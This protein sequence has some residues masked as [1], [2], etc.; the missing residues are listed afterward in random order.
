MTARVDAAAQFGDDGSLTLWASRPALVDLGHALDSKV[1]AVIELTHTVPIPPYLAAADQIRVRVDA[2]PGLTISREDD[3]V[4]VTGHPSALA[5][6]ARNISRLGSDPA[7]LGSH[8]HIEYFAD[9]F[10]LRSDS[11][12]VVVEATDGDGPTPGSPR[13]A[14]A[15]A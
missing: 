14:D 3:Q 6:L 11:I 1:N 2:E 7:A 4:V 5:I 9:H 13:R 10:Y 15:A 12:P 8:I